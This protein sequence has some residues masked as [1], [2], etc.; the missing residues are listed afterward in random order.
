MADKSVRVEIVGLRE[1]QSAFR[2]IDSDLK[3][4]MKA[5]FLGIATSVASAARAKVPG[6][7]GA[8]GSIKPRG[9]TR[10]A[11]IAFGGTAAPHMPWL[12]FGGS[13]GRGHR[14]GV[15]WSGA[16]KRDRVEPDRYIYSTIKENGDRIRSEIDGSLKR[17]ILGAG[18]ETRGKG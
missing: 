16:I 5:E 12:N 15:P 2:Q 4:E 10:G 13:V 14:P 7:G 17:L 3:G 9:T 8:A 18:F 6:S 1:V 11:S